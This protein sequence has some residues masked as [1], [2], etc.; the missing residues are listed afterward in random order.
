MVISVKFWMTSIKTDIDEGDSLRR[1]AFERWRWVLWLVVLLWFAVMLWAL[2]GCGAAMKQAEYI[3]TEH[4]GTTEN[5]SMFY[6]IVTP[7][8]RLIIIDGGWEEDHESVEAICAAHDKKVDAWIVTHPHPDHVGALNWILENDP[9]V[10]I[11]QIYVTAVNRKRYLET[12]KPYDVPEAYTKFEELSQDQNVTVLH[13]GDKL[14]LCGLDMQVLHGWNATV[15]HLDATLCNQGGLMFRLT[16]PT[17]SMLFCAD[18][19]TL[20]EPEVLAEHRD[21]LQCDYVQCAHHG[22]WGFSTEFYDLLS[23]SAVFMDAPD[24]VIR[25]NQNKF[26]GYL[27]VAYW[28]QRGVPIYS[29]AGGGG[30]VVL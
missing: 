12:A 23:P 16:G 24:S 17:H 19:G 26:D 9:S 20:I 3:V 4:V 30:S 8:D 6:S 21:D 18:L 28:E 7:E 13:E 11:D 15:D 1:G 14:D 22:N 5:Q 27:L 2:G 29:F 25:T 10:Q